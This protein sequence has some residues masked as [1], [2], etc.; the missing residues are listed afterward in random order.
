MFGRLVWRRTLRRSIVV[1]ACLSAHALV[2]A[3]ADD[4]AVLRGYNADITQSSISGISSGAFMA[5]QFATAWS[6]IIRGVGVIAGGPFYCAQASSAD[7]ISG[8]VQPILTA[9]GPCMKGPTPDV[10][11]LAAAAERMAKA[12]EIDPTANLRRQKVYVFHGYNDAVVARPV[13]DA[14]VAFYRHYLGDTGRG[15]LFYQ[16][17]VGAGHS[18]VI[19]TQAHAKGLNECGD[20]AGP[21][22]DQCGYD[23]AGI[24]LQHIYGAL[25]PGDPGKPAGTLKSF[26]QAAYTAPFS[27][28]VLSMGETGYVY[29]PAD[30][31]QGAACRVHIAMHGCKQ[32][33]GDIGKRFVEY[34]GYNAWADNNGIIVLYPQTT[35]SFGPDVVAPVNPEA[36]WD[37][38]GYVNHDSSYVTKGGRQVAAIKAMLDALTAG[39]KLAPPATAAVDAAPGELVAIDL[40]DSAAALAWVPVAGAEGYRV[41]R[42]GAQGDFLPVGSV[43]GPSF[44]DSGLASTTN[45]RWR[46]TA[47]AGG[48][49]GPASAPVGAATRATPRP[50]DQPGTCPVVQEGN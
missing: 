50:C 36:C 32:D 33:V 47:M 6:S 11:G 44:A 42:A 31:A 39:A 48:A 29:V 34:A 4:P 30:C 10:S 28:S 40:S 23:Q 49:E 1:S 2:A 14:T 8:Y 38:W 12:R 19:L 21:Y 46:V 20:N 16:A 9:T 3:R 27:T 41:Y 15:N 13:T 35:A 17:A 45:Y 43:T 5:V 37:W 26:A 24:I 25:R 18:Q 22:I 7:V